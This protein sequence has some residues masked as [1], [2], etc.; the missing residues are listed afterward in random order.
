MAK[1]QKR[2]KNTV[3]S[4]SI[5]EYCER[6]EISLSEFAE[7]VGTTVNSVLD[8]VY[9]GVKPYRKTRGRLARV[10]GVGEAELSLNTRIGQG[11]YQEINDIQALQQTYQRLRR[12]NPLQCRSVVPIM[13]AVL[14]NKLSAAGMPCQV[15]VYANGVADVITEGVDNQLQLTIVGGEEGIMFSVRADGESGVSKNVPIRVTEQQLK[16]IIKRIRR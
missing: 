9:R 13:A 10:L 12:S 15:R 11:R 6:Q 1:A 2:E 5:R 3:L 16:E 7:L 4:M 8:W 14:Y